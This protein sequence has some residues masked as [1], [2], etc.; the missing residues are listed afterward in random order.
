MSLQD[1]RDADQAL[2]R[3]RESLTAEQ[4][5]CLT[6][7]KPERPRAVRA[8]MAVFLQHRFAATQQI[9]REDL[10]QAGFEAA[11]IDKHFHQAKRIAGLARMAT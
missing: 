7:P 11:E 5:A 8:R 2:A 4:F 10:E 1:A 6:L 3:Y 9:T